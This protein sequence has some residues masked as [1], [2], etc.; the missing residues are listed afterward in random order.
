MNGQITPEQVQNLLMLS[1]LILLFVS[2]RLIGLAVW[3]KWF[4]NKATDDHLTQEERDDRLVQRRQ[5]R[6]HR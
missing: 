1:V 5:Q 2:L 6:R 3:H 4:E